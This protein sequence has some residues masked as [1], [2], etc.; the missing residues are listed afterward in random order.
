MQLLLCPVAHVLRLLENTGGRVPGAVMTPP[1]GGSYPPAAKPTGLVTPVKASGPHGRH[2][3]SGGADG[4]P[5]PFPSLALQAGRKRTG[6]GEG[7]T[8]SRRDD[9]PLIP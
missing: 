4:A 7:R 9:R 5:R 3:G 6:C 1:V 2:V 8:T